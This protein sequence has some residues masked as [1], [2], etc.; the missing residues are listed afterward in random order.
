MRHVVLQDGCDLGMEQEVADVLS[1]SY[2]SST[3]VDLA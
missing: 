1:G 2:D 3:T